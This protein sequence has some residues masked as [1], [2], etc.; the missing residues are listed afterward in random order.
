MNRKILL[1]GFSDKTDSKPKEL[2]VLYNKLKSEFDVSLRIYCGKDNRPADKLP[3]PKEIADSPSAFENEATLLFSEISQLK[4]QEVWVIVNGFPECFYEELQNRLFQPELSYLGT[5]GLQFRPIDLNFDTFPEDDVLRHKD[6]TKF[7][8]PNA[9]PIN[10]RLFDNEEADSIKAALRSPRSVFIYGPI[11]TGKTLLAQY[12]HYHSQFTARDKFCSINL[13]SI[14]KELAMSGLKGTIA[15]AYT[16]ATTRTGLLEEAHNGTLF[17][18]E[19]AEAEMEGVQAQL[20]D[21]VKTR[22]TSQKI[23]PIGGTSHDEY[24]TSV[25]F[26]AATNKSEDNWTNYFREDL[27]SRFPL[28]IKLKDLYQKND[29]GSNIYFIIALAQFTTARM[30]QED[31]LWPVP[32]WP[33]SLVNDLR[34]RKILPGGLRYLET[35]ANQTIDNLLKSYSWSIPNDKPIEIEREH[36]PSSMISSDNSQDTKS[37]MLS[38]TSIS[39]YIES[40]LKNPKWI[41]NL[42]QK[43]EGNIQEII[44]YLKRAAFEIGI[45]AANGNMSKARRL[46]GIKNVRL[47]SD[48]LN[49]NNRNYFRSDRHQRKITKKN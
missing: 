48:I 21:I 31:P 44:Y 8:D 17:I 43:S 3:K 19:I 26:I 5:P 14:S 20:L 11:G 2:T 13:S 7:I 39:E 47:F 15:G 37:S 40:C 25:R 49:D 9:P 36:L 10:F 29:E 28:Q 42:K 34:K 35:F 33:A 4:F 46:T 18:D 45:E 22:I 12:I 16:G 30:S 23:T 1:L 24:K 41:N 27:R 32:N 38:T 6:G